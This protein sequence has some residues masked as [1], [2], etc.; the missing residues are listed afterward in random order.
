[1]EQKRSNQH[2]KR[3]E[4][5]RDVEFARRKIKAGILISR[6][7][8]AAAGKIELSKSQL[9]ASKMLLDKAVPSLQAV[10]NT[11]VSPLDQMSEEQL[12]DQ[13][14][15]LIIS[16]PRLVLEAIDSDPGLRAA[17]LA[18]ITQ[19]PVVVEQQTHA[20]SA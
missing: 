13:A 5:V 20:Q 14:K 8:K 19:K 6:L 1:M 17:V 2:I 15:A 11:N 16:S 12:A 18:H 7:A 4:R 9:E 3:A 10:E